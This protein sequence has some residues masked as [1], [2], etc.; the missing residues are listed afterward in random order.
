MKDEE[1][2]EV[3]LRDLFAMVALNGLVSAATIL[4]P[5]RHAQQAYE[6][7]DAMLEARKINKEDRSVQ[8]Y[9]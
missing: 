1:M 2:A 9:S 7:A 8:K 4:T 5:E 3:E 6:Y